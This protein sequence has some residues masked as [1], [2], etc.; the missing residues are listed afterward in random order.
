MAYDFSSKQ[1]YKLQPDKSIIIDPINNRCVNPIEY[2]LNSAKINDA[3]TGT[4][5]G[6]QRGESI[7]DSISRT[8]EENIQKARRTVY[9]LLSAGLH[10]ENGIDPQTALHLVKVYVV[11]VLLY[12]LEILL[13][14]QKYI[15]KL[16]LFQKNLLK[17]LLSLPQTV[18]DP[19]P[20]LL[21]GFLPVE[22][23]LH[24]KALVMLCNI[25]RMN[26]QSI[27][28]KLARR[29]LAVKKMQSASW[30]IETKKLVMKYNLGDIYE[31]LDNPPKK[32]QWKQTVFQNI[33]SYYAERI[34]SLAC[35]YKTLKY[36]NKQYNPGKLHPL[37]QSE[38]T[39]RECARIPV[40]MK[41][42]T[43]TYILQS[44]RAAF[45]QNEVDPTC[46]L[47]NEQPETM[48]HF[49]LKCKILNN[50]R[51]TVLHDI[52]STLQQVTGKPLTDID[53]ESLLS[54]I[55]DC[56]CVQN[57]TIDAVGKLEFH[58][59]RLIYSLHTARYAM[60]SRIKTR[61]R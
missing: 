19:A 58:C 29:Q 57:I 12:G 45:N 39:T 15:A 40:K 13:P 3:V 43:G 38:I 55:I 17:Q 61:K 22:A 9:S 1:K 14:G 34:A 7:N 42:L 46:Q 51:Q 44:T 11:P 59:R 8:V 24:I 41:I 5:L 27:E 26:E 33:A 30:F 36:L 31:L 2:T 53:S 37:L 25:C 47:C 60:L 10:G 21:T 4:H 49:I 54:V 28:K 50:I 35:T 6:I 52:Y 32:E 18:A 20:Y 23:Q 56:S 16:E 48:D